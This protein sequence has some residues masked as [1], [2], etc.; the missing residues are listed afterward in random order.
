MKKAGFIFVC[1]ALF[2]LCFGLG[3]YLYLPIYVES[4]FLPGLAE[5]YGIAESD[6][7]VG[8]IGLTRTTCGPLRIGSLQ[9]PALTIGSL[10][11]EYDPGLLIRQ[12]AGSLRLW[13]VTIRAFYEEQR[14]RFPGI[15]V[16]ALMA[17]VSPDRAA[18]GQESDAKKELPVERVEIRRGLMALSLAGR[19]L[20]VPFEADI[21]PGRNVTESVRASVRIRPRGQTI[22]LTA[23]LKPQANT[24]GITLQTDGFVLDSMS[25][26]TSLLPEVDLFGELSLTTRIALELSPLAITSAWTVITLHHGG[27]RQG[28][29]GLVAAREEGAMDKGGLVRVSVQGP[30]QYGLEVQGLSLE[31]PV[32]MAIEHMVLQ[33]DPS[34]GGGR[35]QGELI[36]GLASGPLGQRLNLKKALR[37]PLSIEA[38]WSHQGSWQADLVYQPDLEPM[39]EPGISLTMAQGMLYSVPTG[40]TL[41]LAGDRHRAYGTY[42]AA[43]ANTHVRRAEMN[44]HVAHA[45]VRGRGE[46]KFIQKKAFAW[47]RT[48]LSLTNLSLRSDSLEAVLPDFSLQARVALNSEKSPTL[49]GEAAF[50]QASLKY[51]PK[52]LLLSGISATLPV[53]WPLVDEKS[54]GIFAAT[55]IFLGSRPIGSLRGGIHQ[56]PD[57]LSFFVR[58][59]NTVVDGATL[60]GNGALAFDAAHGVT[61]QVK[62]SSPW[63]QLPEGWHLGTLI[64]AGSGYEMGGRVKVDADLSFKK[65][66]FQGAAWLRLAEGGLR[67]DQKKISIDG[68]HTQIHFPELPRL[69]SSPQQTITFAAAR[70]GTILLDGGRLDF[71]VESPQ[72]LLLESGSFDWCRGRVDTQALRLAA[73]KKEYALTLFCDRLRL[74]DLL[75]QLGGV[76][77]VGEGTLNGKIPLT[78]E[79]GKLFFSDGFLYSTPG[80]GGNIRLS[81]TALLTAGVPKGTP[82]FAQL[83]LAQEALKDYEYKWAKLGLLS[84]GEEFTMRLQ[85]DGKPARPLPFVYQQELGG[86]ARVDAASQGSHF[87]GISLDVNLRLP[88]NKLLEYN[89]ITKMIQP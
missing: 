43:F 26:F 14:L 75:A 70:L 84:Q 28:N 9:N 78:Y 72:A 13:D 52:E 67:L 87:Q 88:L 63:T 46:L 68:I 73:D 1:C 50:S 81:N 47:S 38:Q 55:E 65:N 77:A 58:H 21:I 12:K 60:N 7:V 51:L 27:Y 5:K 54:K 86:F 41:K 62:L 48:N 19:E 44:I 61:A 49:D 36:L 42:Q 89:E 10:S 17:G 25:D 30:D 66:R 39:V 22:V 8:R 82:Q 2:C 45:L 69:R 40:F 76:T 32:A 83:D 37:I 15:D 11:L 23:D 85:F 53:A 24:L 59:D 74:A 4:R 71:Q 56:K 64:A 6:F 20:L 33:I 34:E 79:D 57:G 31:G 29:L 80:A 18:P 35:I 3:L 16:A